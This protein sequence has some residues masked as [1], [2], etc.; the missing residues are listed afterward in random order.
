[1]S[2]LPAPQLPASLKDLKSTPKLHLYT[3]RTPNGLKV[4]IFL[5]ELLLA[6][7]EQAHGAISYDFIKLAFDKQEQKL[8]E[9][10]EINP[11]GRIPALVDDNV[12]VD[13]RGHRVFETSSILIWLAENYD[14]DFKFW[15][16]NPVDRSTALSWIFWGHG[17]VGP[18]QGQANHFFRYAPEKIPY[19]IKRYQDEVK[20]LYSVLNDHL[21]A[22]G[23]QFI[24][25]NKY[26]IVDM[27]LFGWVQSH[28]WAG[29]TDMTPFPEIVKWL[30]AIEA[31][32]GVATGICIPTPPVKHKSKEEEEEEAKKNSAW[33][34]AGQPK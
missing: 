33:I 31:R 27:S 8:P 2:T 4:S 9:F 13:G 21:A 15:F 18:M 25:A 22:K 3:A 16:D 10:L 17:G 19:G 34:M 1:M 29:I 23:W 12:L 5:E 30:D 26:S 11:N 24:V 20:R 28:D 7:P 6:Y 32:P 14:K